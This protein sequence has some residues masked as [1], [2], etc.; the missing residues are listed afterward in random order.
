MKKIFLSVL[1]L[2]TTFSYSQSL[3]SVNIDSYKYIVID[4]VSGGKI[5]ETR[6]FLVKNLQKAGYNVIN[7][8][9]PLKNYDKFPEDLEENP[10]LGIYLTFNTE[11]RFSGYETLMILYSYDNKELFRRSNT[12]G[13]LLSKAIKNTIS[14]L[15]SYNYRYIED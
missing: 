3:R 12:S 7:L 5:G 8:N 1:I 14:S 6:R 2:F 9:N 10:N 11:A 13:S 4:E 15:T